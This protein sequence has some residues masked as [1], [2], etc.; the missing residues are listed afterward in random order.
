MFLPVLLVR[1]YGLWGWI[2]FAIPNVVGAGAMGWTITAE[3]SRE[4]SMNHRELLDCFAMVTAGFQIFFIGW[5]G[6]IV[7]GRSGWLVVAILLVLSGVLQNWRTAGPSALAVVAAMVSLVCVTLSIGF[8]RHSLVIPST[9]VSRLPAGITLLIAS[10]LGF[11]LCPYL[12]PTFHRARQALDPTA[13]K[14][15]FGVGFGADLF[16]HDHFLAVLCSLHVERVRFG[17]VSGTS[18]Y[19]RD[20]F[21]RSLGNRSAGDDRVSNAG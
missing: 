6:N 16:W 3:R 4:I 11:G 7:L 18:Q 19:S 2:V 13:S 14:L 8:A 12:D 1:D 21:A 17:R 5:V 10:C 9:D 15:A 20:S